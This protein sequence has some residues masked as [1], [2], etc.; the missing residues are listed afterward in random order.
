MQEWEIVVRNVSFESTN[1]KSSKDI[2]SYLSIHILSSPRATIWRLLS[3]E[4]IV[5]STYDT[6]FI[7]HINDG[8][9]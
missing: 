7:Y 3:R 9:N 8:S 6:Y 5:S 4:N 1:Q 2:D